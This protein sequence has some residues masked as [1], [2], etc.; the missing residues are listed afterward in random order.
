MFYILNKI[1]N[2]RREETGTVT[3][4]FV[5]I[6]PILTWCIL[7][8][9]AYFDAYRVKIVNLKAAYTISDMISREYPTLDQPYLNGLKTMFDFLVSSDNPTTVRITMV[10][11][12][13]NDPDNPNDDE[14]IFKYSAVA[15]AIPK[16]TPGT[17]HQIKDSIP[18][19]GDGDSLMIVETHMSYEPIF[20]IG[21]DQFDMNYLIATRPR[22]TPPCWETCIN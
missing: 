6:F 17:L 5:I 2:F 8:M 14:H 20:D 12:E 15:G 3:V 11:F 9:S 16:L 19:M 22:P 10:Q 18:I 21:L 13:A 7:A 4:E 1:R